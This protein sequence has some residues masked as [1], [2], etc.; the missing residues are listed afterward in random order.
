[1]DE[2]IDLS[3]DAQASLQK[4]LPWESGIPNSSRKAIIVIAIGVGIGAAVAIAIAIG[5]S[6]LTR[7]I[8]T[9]ISILTPTPTL[10]AL[11]F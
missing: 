2:W 11:S 4:N 1:M 6:R 5:F 3:R 7:P 10:F 9:A 8:A